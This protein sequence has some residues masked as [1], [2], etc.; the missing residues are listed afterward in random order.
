M[1]HTKNSNFKQKSVIPN[2]MSEDSDTTESEDEL[3]K[4]RKV[5]Q[6]KS[7]ANNDCSSE[8]YTDED[9]D[10]KEQIERESSKSKKKKRIHWMKKSFPHPTST[11]NENFFSFSF[12]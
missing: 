10:E 8:E 9:E 12:E 4:V 6:N 11:F 2:G 1:P 7:A 3:T 5:L